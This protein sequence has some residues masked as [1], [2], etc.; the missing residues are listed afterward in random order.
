MPNPQR[1]KSV[2]PREKIAELR[3]RIKKHNRLYYQES[4]PVISDYEYDQLLRELKLL[5]EA[6]PDLKS[7]DSPTQKIGELPDKKFVLWKHR[8]PMLS[9]DNTYSREEVEEFD[10]KIRKILNVEEIEYHLEWKIDGLAVALH[11]NHGNLVRG[12]KRGDGIKGDIITF[13]LEQIKDIPQTLK[14]NDLEYLDVRGEVYMPSA[15][16]ESWNLS[17]KEQGKKE[18]AN[19]R[20]AA[21]GSLSLLDVKEVAKRPLRYF[22]YAVGEAQPEFL[23]RHD[24]WMKKLSSLGLRVVEKQSTCSGIDQVLEEIEKC[25]KLR[26]NLDF[27]VDGLV[28]KVNSIK[29]QR[30]LGATSKSP[31]WAIAFKFPAGQAETRLLEIEASVGRTGIITPVA[32]LEPVRLSG[33]VIKRASLYNE[34]NLLKLD[35]RP[36]DL[37]IIEK[38]GEVIPKVV[39]VLKNR[40]NS[41]LKKWKFPGKCPVC[42]GEVWRDPEQAA[43]RCVNPDCS[44]QILGRL[45]HFC[46]REAM[47]LEG[48]GPAVLEQ[49]LKNKLVSSCADLFSLNVEKLRKLEHLGE[50]SAQNLVESLKTGKQKPLWR[51]INAL[52][53]ANIGVRTAQ[54]LSRRFSSLRELSSASREELLLLEDIGP[55]AAVAIEKYF[56]QNQTKK[57]LTELEKYNVNTLRL[58][59]EV[60]ID[61][62]FEGLNFVFTGQLQS[63]SRVKAEESV[64]QRGGRCSGSVSSKTNYVVAGVEAGSKLEKAQKLGVEIISE[65]EFMKI[66]GL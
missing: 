8:I 20:N 49:L 39:E 59:E 9:L 7:D 17:Q 4:S 38:G 55:V 22:A 18:F 64:R 26:H 10:R 11:Y 14:E 37:V 1:K 27:E 50:K 60:G 66:A 58:P 63:L 23:E 56:S 54:V 2:S 33:S 61:Q 45:E 42:S 53:I 51:L 36:G 16:F 34:D 35:A 32:L 47:E 24:E 31:R 43:H 15:D 19:P 52:G 44:A 41:E 40:R 46:S 13:L 21:A 57:L 48:F 25:E 3:E 6:W 62:K 5:E 30:L 29:Q 65:K 28:I 12:V